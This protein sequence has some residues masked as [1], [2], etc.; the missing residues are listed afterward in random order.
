MAYSQSS[1]QRCKSRKAS[2][3]RRQGCRRSQPTASPWQRRIWSPP[4]FP[5]GKKDGLKSARSYYSPMDYSWYSNS[6]SYL[7]RIHKVFITYGH[8]FYATL[9]FIMP[10]KDPSRCIDEFFRA[11][12]ACD[13]MSGDGAFRCMKLTV[14]K[15]IGIL[16]GPLDEFLAGC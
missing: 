16:P 10:G 13:V 11:A 7:F 4:A 8:L 6:I 9:G 5:Q 12:I 1:P 14:I 15:P 2:E 3:P